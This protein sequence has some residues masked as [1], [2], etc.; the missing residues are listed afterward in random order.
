MRGAGAHRDGV[1]LAASKETRIEDA[2][3]SIARIPE[4]PLHAKQY[5]A[6]ACGALALCEVAAG[7]LDAH[8]D[9]GFAMCPWDYLGG[10][11]VCEEAC[12]TVIDAHDEPLVT[13]DPTVRRRIIAAGTRDLAV[14][15]KR[16]VA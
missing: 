12:A 1:R 4:R 6:L 14:A 3:V 10:M 15:L 2:V 8:A 9:S 7:G 16:A 13:A 11:L 5:R